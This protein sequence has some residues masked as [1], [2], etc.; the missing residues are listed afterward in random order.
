M[1]DRIGQQLGNYQL[2]SLLGQGGF[3]DVYL[4][5]HIFLKTLAAIK[6]LNSQMTDQNLQA[7]LKEAQTIA[8]LSHPHILRVWEF[9]IDSKTPFLVM[10]YAPGGTLRERHPE[11]SV[12]PVTTILP[13]V[14]Q[15]AAAL[16]YAHDQKLIHRDVKPEN[17]LVAAD[18]TIVLSDFGIA[19]TAH[20]TTSLTSEDNLGTVSYMAP[21]QIKKKPCPA[22]DQY[23][24]GVVVYE[25][26]CGAP[27]FDGSPIE[28]AAQHLSDAPPSLHA[29]VPTV[30]PEAEQVVLKALDK[31]P[32]KRFA[33]VQAF[34]E[35]LE[36]ASTP[37][38]YSFSEISPQSTELPEE[39]TKPPEAEDSSSSAREFPPL[40]DEEKGKEPVEGTGQREWPTERKRRGIIQSTKGKAALLIGLVFLIVLGSARIHILISNVTASSPTATTTSIQPGMTGTATHSGRGVIGT[41]R[42]GGT[43]VTGT[44]TS[45]GTVV[46]GTPT[47]P[48]PTPHPTPSG[49]YPMF[50]FDSQHTHYNPNEQVLNTTNVHTLQQQWVAPTGSS[51]VASSPVVANNIVYIGADDYKLHAFDIATG[52]PLWTT[53][54]TTGPIR[55]AP[56][57]ANG[58][59]YVGA[60]S[61]PSNNLY[62]F[63]ATTGI[64]VWSARVGGPTTGITYSSPVVAN[65]VVYLGAA[66][67]KLYA[68]NAST[69]KQLWAT[70]LNARIDGSPSVANGVVYVTTTAQTDSDNHLYALDAGTGGILWFA[71]LNGSS[72]SAPA[73]ASGMVYVGSADGHLYAFNALCGSSTTQCPPTWTS[74]STGGAID[75]SAAVANGIVYIG[76]SN[77]ILN[78]FDASTGIQR[79]A[80]LT[81]SGQDV[82]SS[83]TIANGVVYFGSYDGNLYALNASSGNRLWSTSIGTRISSA[84]AVTNGVVYVGS[85]NG[86]LYAFH[87]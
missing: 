13:Y 56:A 23:A 16:Q 78:A 30:P 85:E 54:S 50:G 10:E 55:S 27:P 33:S 73:V 63:N 35:A 40:V 24:L 39:F 42:P 19:A 52:K 74:V 1:S 44:A 86:N 83:P 28:T 38:Q 7:F 61:G 58:I 37:Q 31:D 48:R 34:A 36:Q 8:K 15:M 22:S 60:Q 6:V 49:N 62:A 43:K 25:W 5:R 26:L 72:S 4:G 51:I 65:G 67:A 77:G 32:Q 41:A 71:S 20:R 45:G 75:C 87:L 69:G 68:L 2:I 64:Q 80:V 3:A 11:G 70:P 21:E 17:M 57:I 14:K 9:G 76:S 47:R 59:V 53:P 79:W 18:N 82:Y 12:L 81:T 84:P 46:T 29:K 66:D